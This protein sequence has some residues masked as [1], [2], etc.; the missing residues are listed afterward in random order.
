MYTMYGTFSSL[1]NWDA[2]FDSFSHHSLKMDYVETI[3]EVHVQNYATICQ[4]FS[5]FAHHYG[6]A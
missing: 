5:A 6:D 4:R 1:V 3:G 2:D